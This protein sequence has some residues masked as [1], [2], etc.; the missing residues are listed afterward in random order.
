MYR[1]VLELRSEV[2]EIKKEEE[3]IARTASCWFWPD[4]LPLLKL[5]RRP[6]WQ[7]IPP[8]VCERIRVCKREL[9]KIL[10]SAAE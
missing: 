3:R 8:V 1:L 9:D 10:K 5:H 2:K 4:L 7:F 6:F